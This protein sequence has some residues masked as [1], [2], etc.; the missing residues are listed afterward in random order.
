MPVVFDPETGN[1]DLGIPQAL[2]KNYR[3][4]DLGIY[5]EVTSDEEISLGDELRLLD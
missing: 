3:H 4:G 2:L 1:R 5:A